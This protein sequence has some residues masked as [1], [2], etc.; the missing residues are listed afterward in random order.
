[1]LDVLV[2]LPVKISLEF[3][4]VK[5]SASIILLIP[6]IWVLVMCVFLDDKIKIILHGIEIKT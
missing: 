6:T 4:D 3:F 1:M 5:Y 2:I